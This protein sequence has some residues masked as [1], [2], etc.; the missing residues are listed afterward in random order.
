M[1]IYRVA[2]KRHAESLD[3]KGSWLMG[4]R[5]NYKGISCIYA[6]ESRALA[7]LE[8]A[9]NFL[10]ED[11]PSD[12]TLITFSIPDSEKIFF[13][14]DLPI[15]WKDIDVPDETRS[16]GTAILKKAGHLII[17]IPSVV[18]PDEYNYIINPLHPDMKKVSIANIADFSFDARLKK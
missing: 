8:Y 17:K 12:L 14:S 1:N 15:N 13:P 6:S 18:I 5:W 10:I 7:V 16:F 11:I 3:G 2:R 9:V 4:G